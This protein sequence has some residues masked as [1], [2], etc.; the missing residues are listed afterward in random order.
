MCFM[1][2]LFT[3]TGSHGTEFDANSEPYIE[4]ASLFL[5]GNREY[6]DLHI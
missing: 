6:V 1:D 5:E 2:F 4:S 3:A